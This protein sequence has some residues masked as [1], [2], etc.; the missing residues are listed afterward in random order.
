MKKIMMYQ[1]AMVGFVLLL[2]A[3]TGCGA[4]DANSYSPDVI[5][6]GLHFKPAG[7]S[8]GCMVQNVGTSKVTVVGELRDLSNTLVLPGNH[9]LEPGHGNGSFLSI[10]SPAAYYWCRFQ[11]TSG[12][13]ADIRANLAILDDSTGFETIREA[14]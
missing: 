3:L 5:A 9:E 8:A 14:R 12:S 11:V 13:I 7:Y 1:L 10:G 6:T 4:N 2:A